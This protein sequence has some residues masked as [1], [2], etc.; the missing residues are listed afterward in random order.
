MST[1]VCVQERQA[2]LAVQEAQLREAQAQWHTERQWQAE[3]DLEQ[4]QMVGGGD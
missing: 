2:T 1:Y 3:Q 4:R